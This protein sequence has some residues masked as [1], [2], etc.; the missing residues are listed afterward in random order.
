MKKLIIDPSRFKGKSVEDINAEVRAL[1][2]KAYFDSDGVVTRVDEDGKIVYYQDSPYKCAYCSKRDNSVVMHHIFG[3]RYSHIK[4]DVDNQIPLC[5]GHHEGLSEFSAHKTPRKFKEWL[6]A[7]WGT[8]RY[9]KLNA[10]A[11]HIDENDS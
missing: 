9:Y 1:F 11:R 3:R 2:K 10:K 5:Y 6:I 8:A 7:V 4:D